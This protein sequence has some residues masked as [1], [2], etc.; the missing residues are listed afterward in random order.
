MVLA[1][2][3]RKAAKFVND[4][5]E[6]LSVRKAG[7]YASTGAFFMFLS[8]V[9]CIMLVC[10]LI[11]QARITQAEFVNTL[12]LFFPEYIAGIL[13]STINEVYISSRAIRSISAITTLWSASKFMVSLMRGIEH[14]SGDLNIDKYIHLRLKAILYSVIMILSVY[15]IIML[16][17]VVNSL[18]NRSDFLIRFLK[19][20]LPV[21]LA[22]ILSLA[23]RYI[24][25]NRLPFSALF[26]GAFIA[27]VAWSAFTWIYSS[28]LSI[29]NNYG[30]Y[31]SLGSVIIT[32]LW[33]YVSMYIILSGACFNYYIRK[34]R[35]LPTKM[36]P[37]SKRRKSISD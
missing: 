28:W 26:P 2:K 17:V 5:V 11:P 3:I 10:S 27:A 24:P 36:P 1:A 22:L 29:S 25:D 13:K 4:F 7:I 37:K 8:L 20:L 12:D 23:Y 18:T 35:G 19:V 9:P 21:L 6:E 30:L 31:G 33:M 32:L 15:I 34:I 16:T 14:M